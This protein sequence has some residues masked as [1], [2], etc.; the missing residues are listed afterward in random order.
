MSQIFR[1]DE[2]SKG[3]EPLQGT[4]LPTVR[5]PARI[6]KAGRIP[7]HLVMQSTVAAD[8]VPENAEND[9]LLP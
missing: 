7:K 4:D 3:T 8:P 1:P 6:W 9:A 2:V 5:D